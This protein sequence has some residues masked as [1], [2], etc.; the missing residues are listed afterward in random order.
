VGTN[1]SGTTWWHRL[2]T[3][4]PAVHR[5]DG[6][7]KELH[8]FDPFWRRPFGDDDVAR[9]H[10]WFPRPPGRL[11]GEW[12]PRYAADLWVAPLLHRAAPGSRWLMLLRDPWDRYVSE[13][14]ADLARLGDGA[15]ARLPAVALARSRY[16]EQL[17][18][19]FAAHPADQILVLQ[20]ERCR[21]DPAGELRRTFD[22]LGL[23]PWDPPPAELTRAVNVTDGPRLE[24][25]DVLHHGFMAATRDDRRDVAERADALGLDLGL[26]PSFRAG[27]A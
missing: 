13:L 20:H 2:L 11:C 19:V 8:F 24:P 27:R 25:G 26:W 21:A 3:L 5:N 14:T 22:F 10:R 12:T 9:Y 16:G 4:H 23:E 7:P 15:G 17:D 6:V 1:K 18:R